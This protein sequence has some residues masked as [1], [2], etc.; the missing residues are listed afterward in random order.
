MKNKHTRGYIHP[1]TKIEE[2]YFTNEIRITSIV[3]F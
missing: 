1:Q 2:K 3:I